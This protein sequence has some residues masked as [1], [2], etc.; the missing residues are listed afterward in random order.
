MAAPK[1][2]SGIHSDAGRQV[3]TAGKSAGTAFFV[4]RNQALPKGATGFKLEVSDTASKALTS[5]PKRMEVLL[6]VYGDAIIQ[7]RTAGRPVSFRV[8]VGAPIPH[9]DAATMMQALNDDLERLV[10]D[11]M[12]QWF[13]V[14]RR[15]KRRR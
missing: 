3:G 12:E 13:W 4:G 8:E 15:W 11:H 10:R 7:S 9:S 1:S 6:Q 14:H 2:K 5:N